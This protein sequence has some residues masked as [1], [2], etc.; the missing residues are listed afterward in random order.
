MSSET[1]PIRFTTQCTQMIKKSL[2]RY[3]AVKPGETTI[4]LSVADY[5]AL[6]KTIPDREKHYYDT[7]MRYHGRKLIRG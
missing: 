6:F 1:S 2:D 5:E 4:K 7:E 3:I